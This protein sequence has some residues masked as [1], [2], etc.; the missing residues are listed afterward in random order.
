MWLSKR[1]KM[2]KKN[3]DDSTRWFAALL[4]REFLRTTNP[5]LGFGPG[6]W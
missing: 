2:S 1:Q 6:F 5:I 4:V 3:S